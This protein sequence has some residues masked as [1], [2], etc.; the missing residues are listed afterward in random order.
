MAIKHAVRGT[1]CRWMLFA[2][3]AWGVASEA[4]AAEFVEYYKN[5]VAAAEAQNWSLTEEMMLKAIAEQSEERAKVK[6]AFYFRRYLPHFYLGKAR[7]EAGNCRGALAAWKES[8]TQGVVQKFPEFQLILEG[9]Q[10]C[11]QMVALAAAL[12]KALRAVESAEQAAGRS[13]GRLSE[14]PEGEPTG[15]VLVNRQA[16]AE[17]SLGRIRL[18]LASAD[19]VL[20]EVEEAAAVAAVAEREFKVIASQA[21]EMRASQLAV[22]KQKLATEIQTLV[23]TARQALRASEYLQPYPVQ[24]SRH[25]LAV[26]QAIR[27]AEDAADGSLSGGELQAVRAELTQATRNLRRSASPPP[28]DLQRAARA[29]LDQDYSS[30]LSILGESEFESARASSHAHLLQAAALHALYFSTG[31]E[32][33]ELLQQAGEQVLACHGADRERTP[34]TAVFSPSFVAFYESQVSGG[35]EGN[36]IEGADEEL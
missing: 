22:R 18:R 26:E 14:L 7:F 32:N 6:K 20:N 16:E 11:T 27:N 21:N 33:A 17:A 8:E 10:A 29:F 19:I 9:R 3:L 5:G 30:V 35:G 1:G 23:A 24:V 36:E 34:P 15:K 12:D 25:R 28:E 4:R 31:A 2:V 13:R